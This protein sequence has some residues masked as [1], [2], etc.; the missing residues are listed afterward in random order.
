MTFMFLK[1]FCVCC[2]ISHFTYEISVLEISQVQ[3]KVESKNH[4]RKGWFFMVLPEKIEIE[5]N[6]QAEPAYIKL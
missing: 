3:V 6:L 5:P 2:K 1:V 4:K